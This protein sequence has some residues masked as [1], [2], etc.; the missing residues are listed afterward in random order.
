MFLIPKESTTMGKIMTTLLMPVKKTKFVGQVMPYKVWS[1]KL[2]RNVSDWC[3][4]YQAKN[5]NK[6]IVSIIF[7]TFKQFCFNMYE[8]VC[9]M[10]FK[11]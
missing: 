8:Y 7:F 11:N 5:K 3:K 10:W 2:S 1:K 6:I 4:V 9:H